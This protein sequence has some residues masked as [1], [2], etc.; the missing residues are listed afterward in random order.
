MGAGFFKSIVVRVESS[1]MQ[2]RHT[3]WVCL[4]AI[5]VFGLCWVLGV[6]FDDNWVYGVNFISNLRGSDSILAVVAFI[7]GCCLSGMGFMLFGYLVNRQCSRRVVKW[8][9]MFCIVAGLFLIGVGIFHPNNPIHLISAW[10]VGVAT[11]FLLVLS[12]L[13]DYRNGRKVMIAI[14]LLFLMMFAL[15][16]FGNMETLEVNAVILLLIWTAIKCGSY[17]KYNEF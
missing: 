4:F 9:Y 7:V 13:D 3:V 2:P 5:F 12:L 14:T 16:F 17:I 1:F 6:V 8:E 11:A 15:S 10:S